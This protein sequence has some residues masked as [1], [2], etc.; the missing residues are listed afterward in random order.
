[1]ASREDEPGG[2]GGSGSVGA[3]S[4]GDVEGTGVSEQGDDE[5]AASGEGVGDSATAHLGAVFVDGDIADVVETVLDAPVTAAQRE[6]RLGVGVLGCEA[7]DVVL[8]IDLGGDDLLAA[9]DEPV[10]LDTA[11]L[12]KMRPGC[13]VGSRAADVGVLLGVSQRPEHP[14]LTPAMARLRD[15]N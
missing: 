15:T 5:V 11:D 8:D 10:A 6:E 13:P 9:N 1:M 3:E 14:D 4:G 12:A 2:V 7:G